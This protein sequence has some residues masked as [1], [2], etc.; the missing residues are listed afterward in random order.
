MR[1]YCFRC[2][3][4]WRHEVRVSGDFVPDPPMCKC[5]RRSTRDYKAEAVGN[6]YH[7]TKGKR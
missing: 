3:C 7:P 5:G 2:E 4:G 6:T 1:R